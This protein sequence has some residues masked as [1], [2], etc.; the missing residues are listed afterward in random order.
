M[1]ETQHVAEELPEPRHVVF[2]GDEIIAVQQHDDGISVLFSRMYEN[3][4]RPRVTETRRVQAHTV[5]KS[6]FKELMIRTSGGPHN[7]LCLQLDRIPL[8]L[9]SIPSK[10]LNADIKRKLVQ[11]QQE[12]A[13]V[14]WN[15]F[16][17]HILAESAQAA[18]P[19]STAAE[20]GQLAQLAALGRAR[21]PIPNI[22]ALK[23]SKL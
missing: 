6:G 18:L 13:T 23:R 20:V 14:L 2:Y 21:R 17:P 11:Y 3:L 19:Q 22:R 8:W 12:A 9:A 4:Q 5:L 16:R 1:G 15:A 7:L 10:R